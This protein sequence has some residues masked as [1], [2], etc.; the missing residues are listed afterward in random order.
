MAVYCGAVVGE[1]L[2]RVRRRRHGL[3][4]L[5]PILV[6]LYN[7]AQ[8]STADGAGDVAVGTHADQ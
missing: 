2:D 8:K 1:P 5:L 3:V 6:K 4:Y 7:F